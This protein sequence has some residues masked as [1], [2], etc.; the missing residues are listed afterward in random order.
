MPRAGTITASR[1]TAP[2]GGSRTRARLGDTARA[3]A[4]A[5]EDTNRSLTRGI[6]VLRALQQ[7]RAATLAQLH[8]DTAIPK[9]TLLRLLRTLEAERIVWRARADGAWRPAVQLQPERILS[10]GQLALVEAAMPHLEALR[11]KVVWPSDL[12]VPEGA[13]MRLLETTRRASRLAL[14]LDEIGHRIDLVRSAVGRAYL[15][16][17]APRERDRL[18][19]QWR[20]A[21]GRGADGGGT[22]R[23][24]ILGARAATD[25]EIAA[26]LADVRRRG[27]ALRDARYGGSDADIAEFDD[28]LAAIAVPVLA[29]EQ[30]IACVNL[31]WLRRLATPEAVARRHLADLRRAAERIAADWTGTVSAAAAPPAR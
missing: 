6:A 30:V 28:G 26:T 20:R 2:G 22:G 13:A 10:A 4:V 9:P 17:C 15:A 11:A 5:G 25:E 16:W 19:R 21:G 14:N 27:Y 1:D 8:A 24:G 23:G 7:R 31:V 18:L 12:A 3:A 29:G